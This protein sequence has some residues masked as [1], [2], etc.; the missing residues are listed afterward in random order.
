MADTNVSCVWNATTGDL[1]FRS[2]LPGST[3]GPVIFRINA[4]Y[5]GIDLQ[6]GRTATSTNYSNLDAN[7]T[8]TVT[9]NTG[10]TYYVPL[11]TVNFT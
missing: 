10:T 11:S 5:N 3:T 7:R 6:W 1:E 9:D 2:G 4:A 8:L